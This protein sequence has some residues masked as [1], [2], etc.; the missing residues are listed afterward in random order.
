MSYAQILHNSIQA[1]GA[2]VNCSVFRKD[3]LEL[4][5]HGSMCSLF[6]RLPM[7]LGFHPQYW[8]CVVTNDLHLV[9]SVPWNSHYGTY[10]SKK[11]TP[12]SGV[13]SRNESLGLKVYAILFF[14]FCFQW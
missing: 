5:L 4:V 9:C 2:S 1:I 6:P 7:S 10:P 12:K 14:T 3:I 8:S 11:L 13:T